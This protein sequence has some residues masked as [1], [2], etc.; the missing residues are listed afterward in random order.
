[1]SSVKFKKSYHQA[2]IPFITKLQVEIHFKKIAIGR[3]LT[4]QYYLQIHLFKH[5]RLSLFSRLINHNSACYQE[6]KLLMLLNFHPITLTFIWNHASTI[7]FARSCKFTKPKNQQGNTIHLMV[8]WKP[9]DS[10]QS[11]LSIINNPLET[12]LTP[13]LQQPCV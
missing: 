4:H 6:W 10:V 3:L 13:L 9:K 11:L 1:M 5:N 12:I 2:K 8:S 7:S